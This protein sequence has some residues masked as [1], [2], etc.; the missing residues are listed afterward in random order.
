[1][2]E[3]P[4]DT[5]RAMYALEADEFPIILVTITRGVDVFR[6]SSDSTQRITEDPLA[7]G[8]ISSASGSQQTYL[9]FP[10]KITLPQDEAESPPTLK[11]QIDNITGEIGWWLRQSTT[12][13]TLD[14]LVV[15]SGALNTVVASFPDF[16]MTGFSGG[17][18]QIQATMSLP[19]LEQ[20]PFPFGTFNITNF[21]GLF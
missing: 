6:L 21:P 10:F 1:M 19:S 5:L 13:P 11:I 18:M 3:I 16:E 9:F 17:S 2:R 20:E 15:S 8:T 7:Y 4:L 12:K 14:V